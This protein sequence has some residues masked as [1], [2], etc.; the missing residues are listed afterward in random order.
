MKTTQGI[1]FIILIISAAA[2]LYFHTEE[3]STVS[4]QTVTKK[5]IRGRDS[6]DIKR[7]KETITV[8]TKKY[9]SELKIKRMENSDHI[10]TD[11]TDTYSLTVNIPQ[12]TDTNFTSLDYLLN[13]KAR[14]VMRTDTIYKVR[15][16]TL[17][18]S[19]VRSIIKPNP[20]Y[21]TFWFGSALT[22]LVIILILLIK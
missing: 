8:K 7:G 19:T 4:N 16:D 2:F 3:S 15:T 1:V 6:T 17:N 13:I 5:I 14:E 22:S 9:H 10:F 18:I 11:S 20:F 21:N 12:V